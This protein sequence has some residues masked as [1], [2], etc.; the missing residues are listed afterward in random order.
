MYIHT[1][2]LVVVVPQKRHSWWMTTVHLSPH[3]FYYL[4]EILHQS[5]KWLYFLI[6]PFFFII[7]FFDS[8]YRRLYFH[9]TTLINLWLKKKVI[10]IRWPFIIISLS[11]RIILTY[12]LVR[13]IRKSDI[14]H[15]KSSL[16]YIVI[17]SLQCVVC[18]L[19]SIC[20][21]AQRERKKK[22]KNKRI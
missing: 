5:R 6:Y 11:P 17:Y 1:R 8:S 16:F 10:K 14:S 18:V 13:S 2:Q 4:P 19:T 12:R 7:W 21:T 20:R 15:Q 9:N 3:L 22:Q